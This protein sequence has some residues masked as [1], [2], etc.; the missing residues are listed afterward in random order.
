MHGLDPGQRGDRR[1]GGGGHRERHA[2]EHEAV[3]DGEGSFRS[4]CRR[5]LDRLGLMRDT[6]AA[7]PRE[8]LRVAGPDRRPP[9]GEVGVG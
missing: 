3:A 8:Q 5:Q 6:K 7:Q 1:D 4:G 2:V 9:P